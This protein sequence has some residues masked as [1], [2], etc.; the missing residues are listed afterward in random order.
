MAVT[1]S[2]DKAAQ[3]IAQR[4]RE[5]TE[6]G[7][8]RIV[9]GAFGQNLPQS[10]QLV[11]ANAVI[12][13]YS[14]D[15]MPEP[16]ATGGVSAGSCDWSRVS[17]ACASDGCDQCSSDPNNTYPGSACQAI[18]DCVQANPDCSTD[19]DP[20]CAQRNGGEVSACTMEAEGAGSAEDP[21]SEENPYQCALSLYD[22][23]CSG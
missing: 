10:V 1:I 21:P 18:I 14:S 17:G 22:C 20:L 16:D 12:A 4:V 2:K 8:D 13:T 5:I 7:V 15:A 9:E 3:S 11:R 23:V 19:D 6:G